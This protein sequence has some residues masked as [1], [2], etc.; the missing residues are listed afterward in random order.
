MESETILHFF[1]SGTRASC[2]YSI[3]KLDEKLFVR[4]LRNKLVRLPRLWTF[5][6]LNVNFWKSIRSK[7]L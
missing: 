1:E 5:L 3:T 6:L 4:L 2:S 7:T